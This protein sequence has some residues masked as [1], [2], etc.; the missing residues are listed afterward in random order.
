[1]NE[2]DCH[3]IVFSSSAT[4]YDTPVC[5]PYNESH[6]TKPINQRRLT[7]SQRSV[8]RQS[9]SEGVFAA[10]LQLSGVHISGLISENPKGV[11]TNLMPYLAQISGGIW[12]ALTTFGYI[13]YWSGGTAKHD[14]VY[15]VDLERGA[16]CS[17]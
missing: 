4:N 1:M 2:I 14:Y 5:L 8:R 17:N 7:Q 13:Y 16:S 3:T 12:L 15:V 9:E 6:S 11:P 10:L